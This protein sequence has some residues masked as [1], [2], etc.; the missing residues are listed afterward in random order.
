MKETQNTFSRET[1]DMANNATDH[2]AP[3]TEQTPI[4]HAECQER[5]KTM[6]D[7]S[8]RYTIQDC[9]NAIAA[10]PNGHK[11]GY[12]TDEIHYCS[13]ELAKRNR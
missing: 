12:Y 6:T 8:L 10:M 5:V 1:R 13:M 4:D 7:E 11:V 2:F 3:Q 9:K